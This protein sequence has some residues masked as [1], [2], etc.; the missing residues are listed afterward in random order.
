MVIQDA[1]DTAAAGDEVLVA[2]GTYVT[3]GRAVGTNMLANRVAV[4][5]PIWLHSVSGPTVTTIVGFQAA[6]ITNGG[7]ASHRKRQPGIGLTRCWF[8]SRVTPI[9]LHQRGRIKSVGPT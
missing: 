7:E 3:G 9:G 4:E 5:K 2:N 1:V 6:G 8:I